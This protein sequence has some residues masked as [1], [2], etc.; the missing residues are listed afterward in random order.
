MTGQI[1][2]TARADEREPCERVLRMAFAEYVQALGRQQT[3]D[4]YDETLPRALIE[5]RVWISADGP[6][7]MGVLILDQ[8]DDHWNIA[9]LAV[10][11]AHRGRKLGSQ[12]IDHI[13]GLAQ[14]SEVPKLTLSTAEKMHHLVRLYTSHG[15]H[16]ARRGPPPHGKDNHT[17]VFMEKYLSPPRQG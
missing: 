9:Q 5:Q 10:H 17:R 15:F 16:I 12:L 14:S 8:L 13:K 4:A 1:I 3:A 2:R 6:T 7:M 11:P